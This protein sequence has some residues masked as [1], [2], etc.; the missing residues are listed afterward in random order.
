VARA[1]LPTCAAMVLA[2]TTKLA[3]SQP[4]EGNIPDRYV[5]VLEED[6]G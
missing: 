3:N 4:A 6:T 5:V 2:Q 1:E